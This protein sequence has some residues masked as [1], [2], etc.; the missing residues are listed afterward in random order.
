MVGSTL[1]TPKKYAINHAGTVGIRL[2]AK[3]CSRATK[4]SA[5]ADSTEFAYRVSGAGVDSLKAHEMPAFPSSQLPPTLEQWVWVPYGLVRYRGYGWS[6]KVFRTT[7]TAEVRITFSGINR[8]FQ[9][10]PE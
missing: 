3:N 10:K 9:G 8:G 4:V 7:E 1:S 5:Q 2:A 6:Q